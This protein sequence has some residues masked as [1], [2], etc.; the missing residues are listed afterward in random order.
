MLLAVLVKVM[1]SFAHVFVVF[2]MFCLG[3]CWGW[4]CENGYPMK[5]HL[6]LV[7]GGVV[8]TQAVRG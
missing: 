6:N 8:S 1:T 2:P 3:W 7:V 4:V 5:T